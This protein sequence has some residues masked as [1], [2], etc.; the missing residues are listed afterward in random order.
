MKFE[1]NNIVEYSEILLVRG[2]PNQNQNR[3]FP[4]TFYKSVSNSEVVKLE[5]LHK[6]SFSVQKY[7]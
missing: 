2:G 4:H 6:L 3:T 5:N 7:K 1:G